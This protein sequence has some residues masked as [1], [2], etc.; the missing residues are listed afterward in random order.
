M[1]SLLVAAFGATV[2]TAGADAEPRRYSGSVQSFEPSAGLIVV[3]EIGH[4]GTKTLVTVNVRDARV[5]RVWRDPED[6]ER[7]RERPVRIHRLPVGTFVV[8]VGDRGPEGVVNATRVE[9][10][11][12]R[13]PAAP[14]EKPAPGPSRPPR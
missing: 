13:R 4:A 12:V 2:L 7:W 11:E 9:V 10:P 3:R 1:R 8:V 14:E 6:P 5:I